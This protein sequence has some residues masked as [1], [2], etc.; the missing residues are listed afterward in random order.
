MELNQQV[1]VHRTFGQ[2]GSPWEFNLRNILRWVRSLR[3]RGQPH[4]YRRGVYF[5]R[6][7]THCALNSFPVILEA[8]PPSSAAVYMISFC[9]KLLQLCIII[10]HHHHHHH[11]HEPMSQVLASTKY[12]RVDGS[13]DREG[14]SST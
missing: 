6:F 2:D 14:L 8:G 10:H 4:K 1:G 11:H 12:Y 5:Q 9:I 7:R 3:A 13:T